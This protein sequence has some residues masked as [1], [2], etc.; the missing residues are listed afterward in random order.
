MFFLYQRQY[1]RYSQ[2]KFFGLRIF[3][4][5]LHGKFAK[6]RFTKGEG[7]RGK[8]KRVKEEKKLFLSHFAYWLK[9]GS[10][11]RYGC[12]FLP[13]FPLPL[14]PLPLFMTQVLAG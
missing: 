4:L 9:L 7:E 3:I 13:P 6:L 8:E 11:T 2:R 1:G 5:S 12:Q 10:I 14:S